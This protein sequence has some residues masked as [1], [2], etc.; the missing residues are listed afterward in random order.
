MYGYKDLHKTDQCALYD[1][2]FQIAGE[3]LWL[4]A[5]IL[6]KVEHDQVAAAK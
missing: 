5:Y 2:I 6:Q 3:L 1:Q 4:K